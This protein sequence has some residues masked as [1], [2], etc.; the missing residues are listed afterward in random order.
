M[1][2]ESLCKKVMDL[3]PKIRFV[4]IINFK[5]R[6]IAG[7]MQ[8]GIEPLESSKDR[9]MLFMQ[10][11]LR[12]KMRKEFDKQFG[13]VQFAM[14][15][16]EKCIIMSFTLDDNILYVSTNTSIDFKKTSLNIL[17]IIRQK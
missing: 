8:K 9:E 6:L 1:D 17:K 5:G 10:L 15:Y 16:R 12:I 2:W 11:A 13:Q 3:D 14:A 7:G 4:G